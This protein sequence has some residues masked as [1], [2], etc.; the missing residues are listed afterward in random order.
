VSLRQLLFTL[1]DFIMQPEEIIQQKEWQ[2]LTTDEKK[3]LEPLAADEQEFNLLKKMLMV[4]DEVS[5]EVPPIA[6]ALQDQLSRSVKRNDHQRSDRKIWYYAAATIALVAVAAWFYLR[7]DPDK[8]KEVVKTPSTTNTDSP[9]V[10]NPAVP[11]ETAKDSSKPGK[12][13][14][15]G[16]QPA[17][18]AVIKGK[19]DSTQTKDPAPLPDDII[20]KQAIAFVNISTLIKDDTK[21]LSLITE[22]Y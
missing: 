16:I 15:P 22:V 14:V 17:E 8:N 19:P 18:V 7:T 6:P 13:I 10:V 2:Q 4:A 12:I 20:N 21:L 1:K 5:A 3:A 9:I 11:K